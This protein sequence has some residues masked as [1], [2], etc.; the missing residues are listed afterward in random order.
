MVIEEP[1]SV[2]IIKAKRFLNIMNERADSALK[3]SR[4]KL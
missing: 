3:A 1:N 4:E 2:G